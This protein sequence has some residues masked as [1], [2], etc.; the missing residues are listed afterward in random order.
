MP[1]QLYPLGRTGPERPTPTSGSASA[2]RGGAKIPRQRV[3][4]NGGSPS[5]IC[6]SRLGRYLSKHVGATVTLAS[7]PAHCAAKRSSCQPSPCPREV[8][9]KLVYFSTSGPSQHTRSVH[10]GKTVVCLPVDLGA[11][12]SLGTGCDSSD[13]SWRCCRSC[14]GGVNTSLGRITRHHRRLGG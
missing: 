1:R 13:P 9:R 8:K 11:A 14:L 7:L 2:P 3:S 5:A 4:Q 10:R 6:R 12:E